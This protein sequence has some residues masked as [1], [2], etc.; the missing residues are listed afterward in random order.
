MRARPRLGV[1]LASFNCRWW[2]MEEDD[3]ML[4]VDIMKIAMD[5]HRD[6]I[7]QKH[8]L[9]SLLFVVTQPET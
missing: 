4:D 7:H 5:D 8:M 9:F 1:D 2:C 3:T 6:T